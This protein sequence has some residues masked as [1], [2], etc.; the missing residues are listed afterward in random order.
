MGSLS[1]ISVEPVL[2]MTRV[3]LAPGGR[4]TVVVR[5][6]KHD[7]YRVHVSACGRAS[8]LS[9]ALRS[10]CSRT[11]SALTSA[12]GGKGRCI[13]PKL[14]GIFKRLEVRTGS[15]GWG[16]RS[17]D[18]RGALRRVFSSSFMAV[19]AEERGQKED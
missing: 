9:E 15:F 7:G 11:S 14:P 5:G 6:S 3:S 18:L 17:D 19:K 1:A 8:F 13:T 16:I 10:D 12:S 2:R 4:G